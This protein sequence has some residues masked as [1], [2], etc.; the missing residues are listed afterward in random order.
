[1]NAFKLALPRKA[2]HAVHL[3]QVHVHPVQC[4]RSPST[5]PACLCA[6]F[7]RNVVVTNIHGTSRYV[8]D[9]S[10]QAATVSS[11]GQTVAVV[12]MGSDSRALL[13][14][15][16]ATDG[17][18][19]GRGRHYGEAGHE[20]RF[21]RVLGTPDGGLV[22][23]GDQGGITYLV[24]TRDFSGDSSCPDH[25]STSPSIPPMTDAG[26]AVV[27]GAQPVSA[28][29]VEVMS[30]ASTIVLEPWGNAKFVAGCGPK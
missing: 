28:Q 20:S 4:I 19:L 23:L 26:I 18:S 21:G 29:A 7:T 13:L 2:T 11:D 15:L 5:A 9:D 6:T 3:V 16:N 17:S 25:E 24:K 1:V 27:G 8:D 14:F 22:M 10:S 12:G 30:R